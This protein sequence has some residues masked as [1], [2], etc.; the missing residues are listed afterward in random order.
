MDPE[1]RIQPNNPILAAALVHQENHLNAMTPGNPAAADP[2][3]LAILGIQPFPAPAPQGAP[4]STIAQP[5]APNAPRP[6]PEDGGP[7]GPPPE[8]A[9][10]AAPH[11]PV[12]PPNT[13]APVA[14]AAANTG[15]HLPGQK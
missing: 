3:L 14:N 8:A 10:G 15:A 12:L 7:G 2:R 9:G 6:A 1:L 5:L 13:P 4:A 11:K